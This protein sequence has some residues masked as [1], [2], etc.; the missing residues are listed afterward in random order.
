MTVVSNG[1]TL[2]V[3][4]TWTD[5]VTG[6]IVSGTELFGGAPPVNV[7]MPGVFSVDNTVVYSGGEE[8]VLP[9]G[10]ASGTVVSGGFVFIEG[11]VA[12]G[13]VV[14]SGGGVLI[15]GD[16]VSGTIV[17]ALPAARLSAAAVT[18][19]S[20]TAALPAVRSSAAAASRS[21]TPEA[22]PSTRR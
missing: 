17:S 16:L 21:S 14:S 5:P 12:R 19:L 20:T 7:Y 10:I 2:E 11:G 3:G 18:F 22:L 8:F 13:T 15:G 4:T 9:G 6:N 1:E